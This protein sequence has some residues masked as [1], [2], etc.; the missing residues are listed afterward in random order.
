MTQKEDYALLIQL[1]DRL[2]VELDTPKIYVA[3]GRKNAMARTSDGSLEVAVRD[4]INDVFIETPRG[5]GIQ[6]KL[7]DPKKAYFALAPKDAFFE[8]SAYTP[9]SDPDH[10]IGDCKGEC[11][12]YDIWAI[13]VTREGLVLD[14]PALRRAEDLIVKRKPHQ[15]SR[16]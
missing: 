10:E 12:N 3:T 13:Y 4:G 6:I 15:Y 11:L 8:I 2:G 14:S 7:V 9:S 16:Y 5:P 1:A